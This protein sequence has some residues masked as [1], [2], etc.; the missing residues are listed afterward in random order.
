MAI[1]DTPMEGVRLPSAA[2]SSRDFER[3]FFFAVAVL[4]PLAVLIGFA[5]TFYLK[6][7]FN[8]P[9]IPRVIVYIHAFV[10]TA[11]IALFIT[12]VYLIS[13]KKILVHRRLG[14]LG[15]VLGLGIIVSGLFTAIA[16]TKYGAASAPK[17]IPAL[18]FMIV[19]FGDLVVFAVL[20]GAAVYYRKA[21]ATHKR[22]ILLTVI[23]FLPP[24]L[25]RYP[26]GVMD[27]FGPLWFF[28][29]PTVLTL[30]VLIGD[31]WKHRKLN[32]IFLFASIFLI[33]SWWLRL[34]LSTTDAWRNFAAW[35]TS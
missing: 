8:T 21:A 23:N 14:L 19:P 17:D 28:G 18:E 29:I 34:P 22:L 27:K 20:F 2:T 9:P 4:F 1:N 32:K 31:T 15:V 33:A 12:Q 3:K 7:L 24:A 35:L 26:G 6:P 16:A 30:F 5:P 10:M 13:A 11:W 25:A